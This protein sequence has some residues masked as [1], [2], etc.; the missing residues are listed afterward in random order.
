MV[1]MRLGYVLSIDLSKKSGFR[2]A[3]GPTD[4]LTDTISYRDAWTHLNN[5]LQLSFALQLAIFLKRV[6]DHRRCFHLQCNQ[7]VQSYRHGHKF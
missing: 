4:R 5:E 7:R 3:N 2:P 6:M 1:P